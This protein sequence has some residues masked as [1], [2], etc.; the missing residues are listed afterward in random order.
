MTQKFCVCLAKKLLP[1]R[2]WGGFRKKC[3]TFRFVEGGRFIMR[4][5]REG[6]REIVPDT[7]TF[8]YGMRLRMGKTRF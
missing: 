8:F 2:G 6:Q 1:V 5:K 3:F 7:G 4:R